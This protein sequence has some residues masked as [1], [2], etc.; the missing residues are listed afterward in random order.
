M[1]FT[2][3]CEVQI[4]HHFQHDVYPAEGGG[5]NTTPW[6]EG[7]E[8]GEGR[9]QHLQKGSGNNERKWQQW[10]FDQMTPKTWKFSYILHI[11]KSARPL[12]HH[13][14]PHGQLPP[15]KCS[16]WFNWQQNSPITF[17]L[18]Q[19]IPI[20]KLFSLERYCILIFW[21]LMFCIT[22]G[23]NI[24]STTHVVQKK[25]SAN[26]FCITLLIILQFIYM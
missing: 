26:I 2:W 19:N 8:G 23:K 18:F 3:Q 7:D 20:G 15:W 10:I 5:D 14:R 21:T 11:P 17:Q 12:G 6:D 22:N 1:Y 24:N 25:H 13:R 16:I 4:V 9:W